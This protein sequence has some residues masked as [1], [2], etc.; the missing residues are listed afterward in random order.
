MEGINTVRHT[1]RQ[2]DFLAKVDL[3]DAYLTIPIYKDHRKYLRF[4]S[5]LVYLSA[6]TPLHGFL[7]K[8]PTSSVMSL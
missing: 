2:G 4:L 7:Q 8:I 5:I 6:S 3:T 1:V